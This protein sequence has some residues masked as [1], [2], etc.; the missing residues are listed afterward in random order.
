MKCELGRKIVALRR[1]QGLSQIDLA[2]AINLSQATLSHYERGDR[3]IRTHTLLQIA[4]YFDVS[5]EYLIGKTNCR[6]SVHSY[7]KTF[8]EKDGRC[9]ENGACYE[10]LSKVP[11]EN[12]ETVYNMIAAL[13]KQ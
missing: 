9:I 8:V 6:L 3:E 5:V 12:R 4:T 1:E 7:Q 13:A 2:F 10:M 11:P